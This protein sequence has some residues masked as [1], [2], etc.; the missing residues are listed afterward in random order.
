MG[1]LFQQRTPFNKSKL[2]KNKLKISEVVYKE[3]SLNGIKD[4]DKY[5]LSN[6]ASELI[7]IYKKLNR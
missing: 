4:A 3:L 1:F 6:I 5:K 7:N 2:L